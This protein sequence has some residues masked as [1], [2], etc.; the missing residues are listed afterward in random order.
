MK[1]NRIPRK[2]NKITGRML[3]DTNVNKVN[4]LVEII[5]NYYDRYIMMNIKTGKT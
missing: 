5:K 1:N 4:D 3:V 2:F